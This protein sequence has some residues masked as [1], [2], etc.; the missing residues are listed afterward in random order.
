MARLAVEVLPGYPMGGI[1]PAQ[2][3]PFPCANCGAHSL[4]LWH[5]EKPSQVATERLRLYRCRRCG[6]DAPGT[7]TA[8]VVRGAF[9]KKGIPSA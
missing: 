2:P 8:E 6:P 1:W 9:H 3:S 5:T 4:Y 7:L